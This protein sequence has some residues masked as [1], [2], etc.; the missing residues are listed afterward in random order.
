M[1]VNQNA[2]QW[3]QP[4]AADSIVSVP[5]ADSKRALNLPTATDG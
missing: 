2:G 3:S 4:A 1:A 5:D